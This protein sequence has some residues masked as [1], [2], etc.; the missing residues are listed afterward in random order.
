MHDDVPQEMFSCVAIN[1]YYEESDVAVL[2]AVLKEVDITDMFG[3]EHVTKLC[4]KYPLA[5][6]DSC[7]VTTG[8]DLSDEKT[9]ALVMN[10]IDKSRPALVIG[11]PSCSMVPRLKQHMI[12]CTVMHGESSSFEIDKKKAIAHIVFF[13]HL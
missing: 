4:N 1:K 13:K 10:K 8:Y 7:Y 6:G 3:P 12:M 11:N 5:P 9:Q 2:A